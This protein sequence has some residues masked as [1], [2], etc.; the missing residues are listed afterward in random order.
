MS[1]KGWDFWFDHGQLFSERSVAKPEVVS[2]KRYYFIMNAFSNEIEFVSES[3]R[4]ILGY[5]PAEYTTEFLMSV[6]HPEDVPYC[7]ESERKVIEFMDKLHFEDH[8]RFYSKYSYRVRRLNGDYVF[9]NQSYQAI[10][11]NEK[12]HMSRSLVFH[13][14]AE[15]GFT[16][17]NN[18]L[19]I[20]D[21]MKNRPVHIE[22]HY[23]LSKREIEILDLILQGKSSKDIATLIFISEHTVNTHRRRILAK[24][25][26]NNFLELK[27]RLNM[28]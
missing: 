4:H 3:I 15:V 20:I 6:I 7:M 8:Y 26:A 27:Q 24:T 22:N 21:R 28:I 11:T 1:D 10:E 25:N 5:D 16:R 17:K 12:G 9:I 19:R 18:D 14:L 23:D 2:L 13:D